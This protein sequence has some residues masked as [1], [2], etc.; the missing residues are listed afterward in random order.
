MSGGPSLHHMTT[1]FLIGF[2]AGL[3]SPT[4]M[5]TVVFYPFGKLSV[6]HEV[7]NMLLRFGEFQLPGHHGHHEGSAAGTLWEDSKGMGG[8]RVIQGQG[9]GGRR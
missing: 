5:W 6:H 8:K 2:H 4:K 9:S 3:K 7:V 1:S